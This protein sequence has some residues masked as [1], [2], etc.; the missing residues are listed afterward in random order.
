[1]SILSTAAQD[2][3]SLRRRLGFKLREEGTLLPDFISFLERQGAS[4]ITTELALRWALL[5]AGTLQAHWATRLRMVRLFATH[6]SATD[7][8]T[9]VPPLGLL[10]YRYHRKPPHI[11][12]DDEIV[13]LI[14]AA[15]GLWSTKGLRP[16]TYST[17]VGLLA[18]TG[19]RAGEVVSL[20]RDDVDL[21]RGVL[22][23]RRTKFGKSRLVPVHPSTRRALRRYAG[24]RERIFEKPRT[25]SFFVSDQ[26][27]RLTYWIVRW[28][29]VQLS[30]RCGLR[31]PADR[32]G[33]RL[34]DF[35]HTFA[36]RTLLGWYRAGADV[37]Q[38]I[39]ELSTYLGHVHVTDTYWYLSA[40]PELLALAVARLENAQGES[41]P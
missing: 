36:V 6:W 18:V 27:R 31:A 30:R 20:D 28:T 34:H 22:S 8:R 38:H 14:R 1:M 15:R 39:P 23:I 3:L 21:V 11:Y 24:R 32:R 37:E 33:P 41:R 29:F 12:S 5:P 40:V 4:H 19:M 26:G 25:P 17:L 35:R 16:D 9:Q 13:G 10:P 2:Y 7:P